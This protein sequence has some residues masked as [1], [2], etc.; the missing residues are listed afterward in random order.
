MELRQL[1]Y[2]VKIAAEKHFSRAAEKLHI[3]QPSLSQQLSKLEKELG[4]LLFQR[5][6]N[7][8]ELTYAGEVFMERAQAI[9]DQVNQ[10]TR[11]MEDISQ[12]KKG[13]L[14][15]G[16]LPITGAHMLPRVLPAFRRSYPGIEL[17]LVEDTTA[18]LEKFTSSG[19]TDIAILTLPIEDPALD[20]TPLLRE[21]LWLAVPH[22]HP[23]NLRNPGTPVDIAQ[24]RNEPFILLK[25][26]QAFRKISLELCRQAGFEP[27]I[28][29]ESSNIET[30]QSLVA[31]GMGIA[32]IPSMIARDASIPYTPAY[33]PLKGLPH[34]TLVL[35]YRK[36]RYRSRTVQAFLDVTMEALREEGLPLIESAEG[37]GHSID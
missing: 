5:S 26:G 29:F 18:R 8:V 30:I 13:R 21:E 7:S 6:T 15:V 1:N 37:P 2:A 36:S 20:Y 17:T 16:S 27:T 9:L 4:V 3:A 22:D 31:T 25:M 19:Q 33:L 34:R 32:F 10:L 23:L 35:A 11:E 28:V 24:L 14:V 12:L